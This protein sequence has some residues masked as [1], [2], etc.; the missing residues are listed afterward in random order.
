MRPS[1]ES[2][3]GLKRHFLGILS[4]PSP[5]RVVPEPGPRLLLA[6]GTPWAKRGF[7]VDFGTVESPGEER[8]GLRVIN[9]GP[10]PLAL[11][12]VNANAWLDVRWLQSEGSEVSPAAAVELEVLVR[13]DFLADTTLAG[14]VQL[15]AAG[16][17]D[18]CLCEFAVHLSTRRTRPLG[19]YEFGGS[20][21]PL[22]FDFGRLEVS[23]RGAVAAPA[24]TVSVQNL[25]TPPV[26]VSCADL[27][28]WL[29]FEVEGH[30][31]RGP[32]AGRFFERAAPF[33]AEIRPQV[34]A[35]FSGPRRGSLVLHTNDSRAA[36]Q[37][38]VLELSAEI[39]WPS[40]P[41]PAPAG[42]RAGRAPGRWGALS[43][44]VFFLL[45]LL[46]VIGFSSGAF[47]G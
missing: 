36:W 20:A 39:G 8:R 4:E 42:P 3:V 30:Q 46:L 40:V 9:L 19:R 21:E 25:T 28:D 10:E 45:L 24:Y 43:L 38:V 11:R 37:Q 32:A 33:Q 13:H 18:P 26:I 16:V 41:E 47:S 6:G 5:L 44:L 15:T 2:L 23:A 17:G 35:R 14:T 34:D 1:S 31:R 29:V 7:V 12:P 27:P 22:P